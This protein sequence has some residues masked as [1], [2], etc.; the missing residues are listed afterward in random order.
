SYVV[1]RDTTERLVSRAEGDKA[2]DAERA[3][4]PVARRE[5]R[6]E[7]LMALVPHP[8]GE[9]LV[10]SVIRDDE[11]GLVVEEFGGQIEHL[12]AGCVA[13]HPRVDNLHAGKPSGE[14]RGQALLRGA[15]PA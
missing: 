10:R 1:E 11:V 6:F 3:A 15:N 12:L 7:V 2:S 5:A 9:P 8:H 4:E 14:V 13:H